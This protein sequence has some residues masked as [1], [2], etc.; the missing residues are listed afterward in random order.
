[1]MVEGIQHELAIHG[2]GLPNSLSD[3]ELETL[4]QLLQSYHALYTL[5]RDLYALEDLADDSSSESASE[6]TSLMKGCD[7]QKRCSPGAGVRAGAATPLCGK[8]GRGG[9]LHVPCVSR[10]QRRKPW[11]VSTL[12]KRT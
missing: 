7:A 6:L 10:G 1:M 3:G 11:G 4:G 5:H 2:D 12:I 8:K 9:P